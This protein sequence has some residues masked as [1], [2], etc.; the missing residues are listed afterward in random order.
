MMLAHAGLGVTAIGI[1]AV[2]AW[3]SS[4]ILEM[5]VGQT[6][7]LAG[8]Q[9]TLNSIGAAQGP[10]YQ[11]NQARFT[12]VSHAGSRILVSERR[13]FPA[14][15]TTTTQAGIGT[16]FL[17]NVYIS[18]GEQSAGGGL[19]VRL[20]DH[21]LVDWI[22]AGGFLMVLGGAMS[23]SDRRFRVG[24]ARSALRTDAVRVSA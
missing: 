20:W 1:T 17:G 7:E 5:K 9:V 14:S 3:Q 11:A 16:G 8:A 12:V 24:A 6:V 18:I 22:W 15:Q 21:P 4:K 10:N 19:V 2:T 23:L 13:L